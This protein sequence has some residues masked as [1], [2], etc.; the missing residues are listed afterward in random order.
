[1][2]CREATY[3]TSNLTVKSLFKIPNVATVW[4]DVFCFL[5]FQ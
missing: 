4:K 1:M 5:Y 2:V 3:Y